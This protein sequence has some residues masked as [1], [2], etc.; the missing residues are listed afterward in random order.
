MARDIIDLET[1]KTVMMNPGTMTE[2]CDHMANGGSMIDKC[3]AWNV[4]YGRIM[5]WINSDLERADAYNKSLIAQM[6]WAIDRVL[7]ELKHIGTVDLAGA[8]TPDGKLKDMAEIP[9]EIRRCIAGVE[10]EELYDGVGKDRAWIGYTKKLKLF[11]KIKAL[12]LIG[13]KFAMFVD[14]TRVDIHDKTLEDLIHESMAP[15]PIDTEALPTPP[16]LSIQQTDQN[17]NRPPPPGDFPG[18]SDQEGPIRK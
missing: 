18:A 15:E 12:E 4:P 7:K 3:K 13:K 10:T 11:D 6:Y 9:E 14:R 5:T 17:Q 2:I 8:Y 1:T 16:P